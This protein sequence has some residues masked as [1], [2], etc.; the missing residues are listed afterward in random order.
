M[1]KIIVD[2]RLKG[3]KEEV[4]KPSIERI[5]KLIAI[6]KSFD[7]FYYNAHFSQQKILQLEADKLELS[8]ALMEK[9]GE[10]KTENKKLL[11]TIKFNETA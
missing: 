2:Q 6:Y 7:S 11:E 3:V 8:T 5:D 1:Q 4:L 9:I 10:L